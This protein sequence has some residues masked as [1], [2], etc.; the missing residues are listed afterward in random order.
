MQPLAYVQAW[1][2]AAAASWI[3]PGRRACHHLLLANPTPLS[4][5][6]KL[7]MACME[8]KTTTVL[9]VKM[10]GMRCCFGGQC[11]ELGRALCIA[12]NCQGPQHLMYLLLLLL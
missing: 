11:S 8:P 1:G 5:V 2:G 3:E 9:R 4:P 10:Q 12:V 7:L 6:R